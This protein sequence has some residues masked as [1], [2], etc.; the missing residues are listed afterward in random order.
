[1]NT[2]PRISLAK[3]EGGTAGTVVAIEGGHCFVHRL[4]A[5]GIIPGRRIKKISAMILRGP[6]TVQ[7]N[8][9][10]VAIGYGMARKVMVEPDST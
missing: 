10:Q 1:M 4:A 8:Q 5:L 2:R 9:A 3:M 6:V 7:V